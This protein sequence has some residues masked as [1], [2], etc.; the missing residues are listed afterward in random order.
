[1]LTWCSCDSQDPFAKE[2]GA[3]D[4]GK[5][6]CELAFDRKGWLTENRDYQYEEVKPFASTGL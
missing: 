3:G 6:K 1:M 4:E 5:S 2:G